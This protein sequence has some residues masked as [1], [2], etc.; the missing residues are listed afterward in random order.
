M[1]HKGSLSSA[2]RNE[3]FIYTLNDQEGVSTLHYKNKG[4]SLI[5]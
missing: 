2:E 1:E 5:N 4:Y 3:M